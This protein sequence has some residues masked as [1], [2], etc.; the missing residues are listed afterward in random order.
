[1]TLKLLVISSLEKKLNETFGVHYAIQFS[2]SSFII[3]VAAFQF[4][5]VQHPHTEK[6]IIILLCI[7]ARFHHT[8]PSQIKPLETPVDCIFLTEYLLAMAAEIFLPCYCGSL[9]MVHSDDLGRA[10]YRSNWPAQTR[11]FKAIASIVMERAKQPM[12][13]HIYRKF[14]IIHLGA[15][16]NVRRGVFW[17]D[18]AV[19]F[20]WFFL[21][22][23]RSRDLPIRYLHF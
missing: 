3:C 9:L 13:V 16:V 21:L 8:H 15:F 17:G 20:D 19:V 14:C 22:Y 10:L 5:L 7:T 18:D 4:S 6:L 12:M 23:S 2:T 11:V 1:M